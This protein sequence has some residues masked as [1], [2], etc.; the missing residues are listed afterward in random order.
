MKRFVIGFI[1]GIGIMYWCLNHGDA[2]ESTTRRWFQGTASNYRDDK[3]HK[4]ARDAL[5][6]SERRR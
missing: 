1:L 2:L 5:G 4:A 3:Q 6:E